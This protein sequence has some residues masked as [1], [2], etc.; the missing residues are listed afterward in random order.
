MRVELAMKYPICKTNE[1]GIMNLY[2]NCDKKIWQQL[3]L[4][5]E[6]TNFYDYWCRDKKDTK[7]I[8][9]KVKNW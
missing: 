1:Q 8:M 7:Y 2:F 3:K 9:T 6:H 5:N 4:R